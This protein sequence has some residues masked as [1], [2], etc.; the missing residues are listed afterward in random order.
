MTRRID[1][2]VGTQVGCDQG[3]DEGEQNSITI[4]DF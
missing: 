2:G 3:A 4:G 1:T